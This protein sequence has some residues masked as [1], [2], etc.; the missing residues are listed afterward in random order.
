[1]EV[2]MF[3]AKRSTKSEASNRRPNNVM[4]TG[5]G[6][7]SQGTWSEDDNLPFEN[8]D[9]CP[10]QGEKFPQNIEIQCI[11]DNASDRSKPCLTCR[12]SSVQS[13]IYSE[14]EVN[15]VFYL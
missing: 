10:F 15:Q 6:T 8:L 11:V 7:I 4:R 12:R 9:N 14:D 1:M 2:E 5:R 3:L 13:S